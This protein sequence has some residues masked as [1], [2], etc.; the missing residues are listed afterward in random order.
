MNADAAIPKTAGD[1]SAM[2]RIS[3][4]VGSSRSEDTQPRTL[5]L[6]AELTVNL[7]WWRSHWISDWWRSHW[8]SRNGLTAVC[9]ALVAAMFFLSLAAAVRLKMHADASYWVYSAVPPALSRVAYGHD[10]HYMSLNF[11]HDEFNGLFKSSESSHVNEVI[12][13][14]LAKYP[15]APDQSDRVLS[16]DD[17]GIVL[18]TEIAFRLFGYKVQGVLYL[19]YIILGLAAACFAYSYRR[20][21]FALLLLAAFLLLHSMI[22]P[23]IKYDRQLTSVTALR[24]MPVLAMISCMHCVLFFFESKVDFRRLF[25]VVV[26]VAII[27]F[28]IH[29]RSTAIWELTLVAGTGLVVIVM[30]KG[31]VLAD[32]IK[33]TGGFMR[34]PSVVPLAATVIFMLTLNAYRAYGFPAEYHRDGEIVTRPFW[35]NIFSGFAYN[36]KISRRY[37]PELRV[38]DFTTILATKKYLLDNGRNREWEEAGGNTPDYM[39]MRWQNY[40]NAVK[41]MLFVVCA[42]YPKDC[43]ATFLYYKPKSMIRT[44]LWLVGA[45]KQPPEIGLFVST[46]PAIG[47]QVRNQFLDITRE[48]DKNKQRGPLWLRGLFAIAAAF[49]ALGLLRHRKSEFFPVILTAAILAAGSMAPSIIGYPAPHTISEAAI[50][51][52]LVLAVLIAYSLARYYRG[53]QSG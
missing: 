11:V 20:N 6:G 18:M 42:R 41:E 48:L 38:D 14:V 29:V 7:D 23:M 22:L 31:P 8:I 30:R 27:V 43:V 52:P 34:W 10:R 24:C 3:W 40:D 28:V 9:V 16:G 36:P 53:R 51:I 17:K 1:G 4:R 25:A 26:Q 33:A 44:L 2:A 39:G 13:R 46:Y 12:A 47:V 50:A 21:P 15:V 19:Y 32:S 49:F 45:I 37:D 35:H 5:A